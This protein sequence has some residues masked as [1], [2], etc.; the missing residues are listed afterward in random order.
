MKKL[1][2]A[3]FAVSLIALGGTSSVSAQTDDVECGESDGRVDE[4]RNGIDDRCDET[5]GVYPPPSVLPPP[6]IDPGATVPVC[7]GDAPYI[8]YSINPIAFDV[9]DPLV[10]DITISDIN[11]DVVDRLTRNTLSG[12]ILWPG[13]EVDANGNAI[14]WPGWEQTNTGL[15]VPDD[16]D[17]ILREGLTVLFEINPSATAFVEYPPATAVCADPENAPPPPQSLPRTGSGVSQVLQIGAALLVAG[18]IA[19]VATRRRSTATAS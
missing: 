11:G 3:A 19:F 1:I 9:P 18:L 10:V 7:V 17:T 13:A 6:E 2:V 14:D 8:S 5:G 16:S 12:Q 4:D 15:W